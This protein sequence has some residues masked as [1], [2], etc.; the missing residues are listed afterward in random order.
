MII[1]MK[2]KNILCD[3]FRKIKAIF[4]NTSA[5]YLGTPMGQPTRIKHMDK[6]FDTVPLNSITYPAIKL[7]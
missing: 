6:S 1:Q 4:E 7:S 2:K 3:Y 5:C